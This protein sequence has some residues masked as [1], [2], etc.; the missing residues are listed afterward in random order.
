MTSDA[1]PVDEGESSRYKL[2][3]DKAKEK[4]VFVM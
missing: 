4:V 2:E 3:K 1:F